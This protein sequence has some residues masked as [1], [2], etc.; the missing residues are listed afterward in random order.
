MAGEGHEFNNFYPIIFTLIKFNQIEVVFF[1]YS[2]G[3]GY[4]KSM[5]LNLPRQ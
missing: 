1:V 4:E 2:M 3:R 5:I